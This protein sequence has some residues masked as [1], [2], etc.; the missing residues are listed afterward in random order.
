MKIILLLFVYLSC[1]M[2]WNTCVIVY[3]KEF[4]VEQIVFKDAYIRTYL[5]T[6]NIWNIWETKVVLV[7]TVAWFKVGQTVKLVPF[8]VGD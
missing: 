2:E 5:G 3:N 7:D 6:G 8:I 4:T 1:S